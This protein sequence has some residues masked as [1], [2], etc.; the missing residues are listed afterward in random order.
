[1][2]KQDTVRMQGAFRRPCGARR[3]NEKR[4]VIGRRHYWGKR[5]RRVG[6][7]ALIVRDAI[8]IGA[9]DTDAMLQCRERIAHT[10]HAVEA[11]RVGHHHLRSGVVQPIIERFRTKQR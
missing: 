6:E 2:P 4:G 7:E 3:V 11:L 8:C 1:M 5:V 9:V 10:E